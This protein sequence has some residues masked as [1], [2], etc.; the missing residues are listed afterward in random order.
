MATLLTR[1]QFR[2]AVFERDEYRC[3]RCGRTKDESSLDAHHIMERRL[4]PDGGYYLEN[5][6]TLCDREENKINIG[7]HYLAEATLLAVEDI[8]RLAGIKNII[9]PPHLYP[10]QIYDKWGNPILENGKRMKGELFHDESVFKVMAWAVAQGLFTDYVK[11]PR[12]YHL[13]WSP[14]IT[15]D[16]R[17]MEYAK[18]PWVD[19]KLA[20]PL[21]R[22][23]VVVTEKMDGEN[24]TMYRDFI[25]ARSIDGRN[26]ESRNWVKNLHAR[27]KHEIPDG[28]RIC[29]EN[30]Y[31][32]HSIFYPDL[33]SYFIVFSIWDNKNVCLSWDDTKAYAE[34]LRLPVVRELY[35]GLFT[36][37]RIRTLMLPGKEPD[38][39]EGYVV[40]SAASFP[41]SQFRY[42][43]AKYVRQNHVQTHGKWTRMKIE[44]NG[45]ALD[46][47]ESVV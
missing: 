45:L 1:E 31:A 35:V 7:C 11:Y 5:G 36:E 8:R 30:L 24:T 14:G 6:A 20:L 41:Y 25:H 3:V 17:V 42:R 29:G 28:W 16:D 13:P 34:M 18:N 23:A 15:K 10:D 38:D 21:E 43:V 47:G 19:Y 27:I 39:I 46:K 9:L 12:T 26:H 22:M 4:F 40:R 33:P 2:I 37:E 44:P 32:K